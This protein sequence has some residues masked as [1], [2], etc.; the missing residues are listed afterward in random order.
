MRDFREKGARKRDKDKLYRKWSNKR[1]GTY[2]IIHVIGTA[3]IREQYL[4]EQRVKS[5]GEYREIKWG[6]YYAI[7]MNNLV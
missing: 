2:F 7:G 3:L 4:L 5:W 6:A 1:R